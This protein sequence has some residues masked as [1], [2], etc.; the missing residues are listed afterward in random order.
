MPPIQRQA[1]D[2]EIG[3]MLADQERRKFALAVELAVANLEAAE[4]FEALMRN[5]PAAIMGLP[6]VW[7]SVQK[8]RTMFVSRGE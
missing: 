2:A 5:E 4:R 6:I 7:M 1:E 8:P 3:R